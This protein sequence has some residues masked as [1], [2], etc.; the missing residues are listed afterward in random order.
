MASDQR[1]PF[2]KSAIIIL[3]HLEPNTEYIVR[4]VITTI[5][6]KPIIDENLPHAAFTTKCYGTV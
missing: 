5:D 2:N 4:S 1:N 6:K 3:Q